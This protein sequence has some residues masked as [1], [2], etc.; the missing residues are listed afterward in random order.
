[1]SPAPGQP[2][3]ARMVLSKSGKRPH[4]VV[5][6][7]SGRFKCYSDCLNFKSLGICSHCVAVAQSN[8]LLT[9]FLEHFQKL[10]KK[11]N[12]TAV[13]LHG[14]PAGCGKKGNTAPRK[15]RK[16]E[17]TTKRVNRFDSMDTS[18][19]SVAMSGAT[20]GCASPVSQVCGSSTV[21]ISLDSQ[22]GP[23]YSFGSSYSTPTPTPTP[24]PPSYYD[25]GYQPFFPPHAYTASFTQHSSGATPEA[26]PAMGQPP[27][28]EDNSPFNLH[29]ISGNI[30]KCAGCGNKY[31]K[32]AL[33]PYDLCVQHREWRSFSVSGTQQSKFSPAYYHLNILCIRRNW[34]SFSPAQLSIT[35][36]VLS[37]L[38]PTHRDYLLRHGF[39]TC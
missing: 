5:P 32:P 33:P 7:K 15:R 12:F 22:P 37:R 39:T 17:T 3:Q 9:E 28:A 23:S 8:N 26:A 13:S 6:C 20:A 31:V 19:S 24:W 10:K 11:P 21:N 36:D 1:M 4:L 30:S 38:N 35:S 34:P 25:W 18:P 27:M 2:E 16:L 14:V 29:F